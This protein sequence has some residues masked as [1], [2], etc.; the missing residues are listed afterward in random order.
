MICS[1]HIQMVYIL[2]LGV[3]QIQDQ[4]ILSILICSHDEPNLGRCHIEYNFG[5][6]D[7]NFLSIQGKCR[8]YQW[9][10]KGKGGP[11][12]KGIRLDQGS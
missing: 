4:L 7:S 1:G 3:G 8:A 12:K 5:I 11:G 6:V 2:Q 10:K 9:E